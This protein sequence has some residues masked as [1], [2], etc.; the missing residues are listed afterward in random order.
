M[1]TQ[2]TK[3]DV[4]SVLTGFEVLDSDRASQD[5]TDL[6]YISAVRLLA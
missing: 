3:T 6:W 4:D 2:A 1:F 5:L